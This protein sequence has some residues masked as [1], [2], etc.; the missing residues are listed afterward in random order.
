MSINILLDL[1]FCLIEADKS[2]VFDFLDNT[3]SLS[4]VRKRWM[5]EDEFN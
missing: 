4:I 2:F 3:I 5:S 1:I